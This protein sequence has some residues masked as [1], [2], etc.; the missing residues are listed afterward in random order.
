MRDSVESKV[1]CPYCDSDDIFSNGS[2]YICG[3]CGKKFQLPDE[4][5]KFQSMHL[6]LSYGHPEAEICKRIKQALEVR[7]HTVWVDEEQI[8][9]GL[10]WRESITLGI[11]KSNGVIACLSRHSVRPNSVC[12]DELSIAI[13]V[14]GGNI[15]TI[16]LESEKDT[17]PPASV[18]HLQWLDMSDWKDYYEQGE[19]SFQPWFDYKMSELFK[20][21]ESDESRD[22]VGQISEI[23]DKLYVNYNTS[24]QNDLLKSLFVG[25]KWL[26]NQLDQW[27]DDPDGA[28]LCLLYGDPGVGKSAFAAHYVHYNPRVVAS[29]FCE[30]DHPHYND[31]CA[32]TMTLA[33]LLACRLPSYRVVL[34]GILEQEKR[35]RELNASE[36]FDLLLAT[37]LST[38]TIDGGHETLC[39]VIDGLDECS[40]GE[41]NALAE[42][43]V[44]YVPRLPGWLR[45]LATTREVSAVK[46]PLRNAYHLELHGSQEDNQ[47]DIRLYFEECLKEKWGQEPGWRDALDTLTKRSGGIFLYARL[48]TEGIREGKISIENPTRFPDGLSDAFYQWFGWFFPDDREYKDHFRLPLGML[49]AAP[50]PLPI[51]E[52]KRIFDWDDNELGDFLRRLEVLLRRDINIF[53]KETITFS[54]QYIAEWLGSRNAGLFQSHRSAALEKMAKRFYALFQQDA[55]KLTEFEALHLT[56]LL[57]KC[58]DDQAWNEAMM[59]RDLFDRIIH[60]GDFCGSRGDM[61]EA[62]QCYRQA[63]TMAEHMKTHRNEPDDRRA[64]S[65]C[66]DRVADIL[67]FPLTRGTSAK[68]LYEK[69]REIR[70][71]LVQESNM[72]EDQRA[73]SI[74]Y[75]KVADILQDQWDLDN[76]MAF[77]Q[78]EW[79]IREQLVQEFG[80]RKDR[81]ALSDVYRIAAGILQEMWGPDPDLTASLLQNGIFLD[82]WDSNDMLTLY[83]KEIA[84][85]EHLV[86]E[87]GTPD[88]YRNLSISY[89]SVADILQAQGDPDGAKKFYEKELAILEQFVQELGTV[90][91]YDGRWVYQ[92]LITT[93]DKVA[94]ILLSH[95]DLD[96]A[97]KLYEKELAILEH[98]VQELGTVQEYD[99]R[100]EYQ[101]LIT[102]YDKVADILLSHG[103]PDGAKKFY[104]KALEIRKQFAQEFGTQK[105]DQYLSISD[106]KDADILQSQAKKHY[107]KLFA[108][109]EKLG[110]ER[111][112]PEDRQDLSVN[113]DKVADILKSKGNLDGAKLLYEK[114]LTIREQ[115]VQERGTPGDR[116]D[117]SVSYDKVADILQSKGNLDGAKL[118][119][120]KALTIREQLVQERGTREDRQ[121]LSVNY[122]KVADIL[123]FKGNL[124][125]AL[126]LYEKVLKIRKQLVQ[127]N[128]TVEDRED[129]IFSYDKVADI[130][131]SKGN[132]DDALALYDEADEICEQLVEVRGTEDDLWNSFY[133]SE[134]IGGILRALRDLD[135]E[136]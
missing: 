33:Y 113:Y 122:D 29:L 23:R 51:E 36:L 17:K 86:Q 32:V 112:T 97:K 42:T 72:P 79:M 120:E 68:K 90:P 49:L 50:E 117:L 20:V 56:E 130:L 55:E 4:E 129:L 12:L 131:K 111:G 135:E 104:E 84:I 126:A 46:D 48:V 22:F 62:I 87:D 19:A 31:A 114:A 25:R 28:R 101:N 10:D 102:C 67:D 41:Q 57:K 136:E 123:K 89:H 125:G 116:Q 39:I 64:L 14:R 9:H 100:W 77:Y 66:Y 21:I 127:E 95:G 7:G 37:P 2:K 98:I 128:G 26:E 8:T 30:Y 71:Q 61:P 65:I 3:E 108:I 132:L 47:A 93:Y 107:E 91:E 134:K 18:C 121:D 1:H 54:H 5:K 96:S 94:D 109:R 119:Y 74:I 81:R 83:Q 92:N 73:L 11:R 105:G 76:A 70:E 35:L 52:L 75:H 85:R 133:V 15:K 110:Q 63:Q 69:A 53:Q 115:L 59:S 40:Q 82:Q 34:A 24:K 6:F 106:H 60:A 118:L 13:G 103:D 99:G 27:L 78:K 44:S 43:L 45:V 16:L 38:L 124:D 88:E 58:D 80:M